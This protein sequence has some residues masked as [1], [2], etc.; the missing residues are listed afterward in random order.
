MGWS[1]CWLSCRPWRDGPAFA[2]A[3]PG[4]PAPAAP[5]PAAA[6]CPDPGDYAI[7]D[8]ALP[9]VAAALRA[10]KAVEILAVGSASTAAPDGYAE[11][12]LAA[13]RAARPGTEFRLTVRGARGMVA[14]ETLALLQAAL[15][16]RRYTL[17]LWQVGTVDAVRGSRPTHWPTRWMP[18]RRRWPA[19]TA[20]S[21]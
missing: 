14:E 20:T 6:A 19:R 8:Q 17:V 16:D 7:A 21:S 3:P 15:R 10:G 11:H 13:L 18:A 4:G 12:M 2:A 1:C 5:V 9:A